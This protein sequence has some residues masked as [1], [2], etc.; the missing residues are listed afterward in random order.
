MVP[1]LF[2]QEVKDEG[3]IVVT[4]DQGRVRGS[5]NLGGLPGPGYVDGCREVSY[6]NPSRAQFV[7]TSPPPIPYDGERRNV[8][9]YSHPSRSSAPP[10]DQETVFLVGPERAGRR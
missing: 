9:V 1:V 3:V 4:G 8:C 2:A 10:E 5:K 7:S 6:R